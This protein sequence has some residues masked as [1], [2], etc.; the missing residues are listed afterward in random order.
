MDNDVSKA[1]LYLLQ[2]LRKTLS[3]ILVTRLDKINTYFIFENSL[4]VT[5]RTLHSYLQIKHEHKF[6][7]PLQN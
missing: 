4:A 5:N 6:L 1:L 3:L 7:E 2:S